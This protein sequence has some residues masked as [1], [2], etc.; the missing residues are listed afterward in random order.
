M[1]KRIVLSGLA[2]LILGVVF[3]LLFV[4]QMTWKN[5]G[6]CAITYDQVLPS[7][8]RRVDCSGLAYGFPYKFV[9]ASPRLDISY[10]TEQNT[11]PTALGVSAKTELDKSKLILNVLFWT[12]TSGVVVG[13]IVY[14]FSTRPMKETPLKNKG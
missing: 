6:D 7:S 9:Q 1:R 13:G 14:K 12:A 2:S 4:S 11:S 5:L 8:I 3:T 10:F